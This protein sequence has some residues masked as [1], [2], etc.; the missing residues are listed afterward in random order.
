MRYSSMIVLLFMMISFGFAQQDYPH[1]VARYDFIDYEENEIKF[2]GKNSYEP[3]FEKWDKLIFEGVGQ[4]NVL[5]FGG[6]HIQADIWSE[7]MRKHLQTFSPGLNASR[8]LIFPQTIARTNNPDNFHVKYNGRFEYCKSTLTKKRE[9][10]LGLTGTSVT[11]HDSVSTIKIWF[12]DDHLPYDF[13]RVKVL[14]DRDSTTFDVFVET[15]TLQKGEYIDQV[16]YSVFQLENYE[17]TLIL[18]IIQTDTNQNY[19]RLYGIKFET[20]DPCFVYHAM[21]VNG[22]DVP[23]YNR[24]DL[25]EQQLPVIAPDLVIFSVGINDANTRYFKPENYKDDYRVFIQRIKRK[26]PDAVILF[27]TNNDCYYRRRYPNKNGI[28]V[29]Q[30]MQELSKEYNTG[31]WD[32]FGVMGGLNSIVSWQSERLAKSDKI[33]FT[34]EGYRLVADL[35]FSA[36]VK[37][38]EKHLQ[39]KNK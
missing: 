2:Y 31:V 35:M 13:H 3:F 34:R 18:K 12:D 14:H 19:F 39:K 20:E 30:A 17:D 9:C 25:L 21:G 36:L 1:D 16:G 38:Y 7:T 10:P 11:T 6:S 27:T 15:D 28:E 33:H 23:A 37:E 8:G 26:Y 32:M 4:I 24:C 5:H 29:R 22:A